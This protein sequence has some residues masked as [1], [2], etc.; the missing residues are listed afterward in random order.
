M[1]NSWIFLTNSSF[2]LTS[3]TCGFS[4]P[5]SSATWPLGNFFHASVFL[6]YIILYIGRCLSLFVCGFPETIWNYLLISGNY[7]LISGNYLLI[8]GNYLLFVFHLKTQYT[9]GYFGASEVPWFYLIQSV[10]NTVLRLLHYTDL[11]FLPVRRF[12][13]LKMKLDSVVKFPL[14]CHCHLC[15]CEALLSITVQCVKKT[16]TAACAQSVLPENR[17]VQLKTNNITLKT[18]LK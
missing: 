7:L 9:Y 2:K 17:K 18:T 1:D 8:W 13:D 5:G 3:C 4:A 11:I 12:K 10:T 15:T 6:S 14:I 16:C